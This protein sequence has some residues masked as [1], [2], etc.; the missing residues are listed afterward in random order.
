MCS[1]YTSKGLYHSK[2][3]VEIT[4]ETF[5]TTVETVLIATPNVFA[6]ISRDPV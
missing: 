3:G 6:V 2:F 4:R 5:T 1:T